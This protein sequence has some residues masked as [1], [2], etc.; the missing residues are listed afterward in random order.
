[1]P[2]RGVSGSRT[3]A[4]LQRATEDWNQLLAWW[5]TLRSVFPTACII[6]SCGFTLEQQVAEV[7]VILTELQ[8]QALKKAKVGGFYTSSSSITV[9]EPCLE[10]GFC[11]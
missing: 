9:P 4:G 7:G 8:R 1:M 11:L 10:L 6:S 3:S 2:V 5:G